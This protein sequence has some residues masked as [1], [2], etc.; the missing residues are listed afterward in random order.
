MLPHYEL[1]ASTVPTPTV[2][3]LPPGPITEAMVG[4]R[5]QMIQCAVSTVSGVGSSSVVISWMRPG[6]VSITNDSR[7]TI[8]PTT[9]SGNTYTSIIQFTYLME[10]DEGLYTCNAMILEATVLATVML[11]T[12]TSKLL[13]C[14]EAS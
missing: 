9:F 5:P 8:K 4:G 6:G 13:Q 1:I 7:V 11:D 2:N 12:L 3:L 10:G 14:F